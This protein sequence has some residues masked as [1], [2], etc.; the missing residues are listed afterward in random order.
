MSNYIKRNHVHFVMYKLPNYVKNLFI[1]NKEFSIIS[2]SNKHSILM[3]TNNNMSSQKRYQMKHFYEVVNKTKPKYVK[4]FNYIVRD[5]DKDIQYVLSDDTKAYHEIKIRCGYF[6]VI[7]KRL[8]TMF[9]LKNISDSDV[10]MLEILLQEY[11]K[12]F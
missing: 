6:C 7:D 1:Y 2:K 8:E 10:E 5:E 11:S 9:T 3:F 12:S 4:Y